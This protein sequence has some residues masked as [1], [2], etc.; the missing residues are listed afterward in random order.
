MKNILLLVLVILLTGCFLAYDKPTYVY[1]FSTNFFQNV[2][3]VYD[4]EY[5][6]RAYDIVDIGV[7]YNKKDV[8][9]D[10][11]QDLH[12]TCYLFSTTIQELDSLSREFYKHNTNSLPVFIVGKTGI[13]IKDIKTYNKSKNINHLYGYDKS[14]CKPKPENE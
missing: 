14:L 2:Y 1:Q 13:S 11:F 3:M 7:P 9:I 8:K 10:F 4:I 5:K 12:K 6:I